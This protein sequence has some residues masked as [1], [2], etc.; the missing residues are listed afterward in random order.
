MLS[1]INKKLLRMV[2]SQTHCRR[3]GVMERIGRFEIAFIICSGRSWKSISESP[4][5]IDVTKIEYYKD[6]HEKKT[7]ID[8]RLRLIDTVQFT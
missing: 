6:T 3:K 7:K 8:C 1:K 2:V 5:P 4:L